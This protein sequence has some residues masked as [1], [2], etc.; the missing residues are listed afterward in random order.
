M[1]EYPGRKSSVPASCTPK[2]SPFQ[3]LGLSFPICHGD[4]QDVGVI[5]LGSHLI[6]F[7]SRPWSMNRDMRGARGGVWGACLEEGLS[8]GGGTVH[9]SEW[10]I[11]GQ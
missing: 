6:P 1:K 8:D 11:H 3:P 2:K 10:T 4:D 9:T 5:C 7:S